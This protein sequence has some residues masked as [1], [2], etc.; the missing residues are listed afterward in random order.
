MLLLFYFILFYFI[1]FYF[2]LFYFILF[3]FILFYFILF[4]FILFYF[5][6]FYFILFYFFI[7]LFSLFLLSFLSYSSTRRT[8]VILRECQSTNF[9]K[10]LRVVKWGEEKG[11]GEEGKEEEEEEEED[12]YC[13]AVF[14]VK[15]DDPENLQVF[16]FPIPS[17]FLSFSLITFL[18]F[19]P[20]LPFSSLRFFFSGG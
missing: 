13:F 14:H 2:I 6:L 17:F 20:S 16:F 7:S 15:Q 11:K 5:I 4:Y 12:L 8:E 18:L 19:F 9:L 10:T 3:Y 1:L